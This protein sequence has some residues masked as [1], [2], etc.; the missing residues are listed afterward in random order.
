MCHPH[1]LS[2]E[3]FLLSLRRAPRLCTSCYFAYIWAGSFDWKALQR[4]SSPVR[5]D[6]VNIPSFGFWIHPFCCTFCC[7]L[8]AFYGAPLS[9]VLSFSLGPFLLIC[10]T[11][12]WILRRCVPDSS[13]SVNSRVFMPNVGNGDWFHVF[14]VKGLVLCRPALSLNFRFAH[15]SE[16]LHPPTCFCTLCWQRCCSSGGILQTKHLFCIL[17]KNN[18]KKFILQRFVFLW[19][20]L[21]CSL[22]SVPCVQLV[23]FCLYL[24]CLFICDMLLFFTF[25]VTSILFSLSVQGNDELFF[26]IKIT[27]VNRPL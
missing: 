23:S 2:P 5:L 25:W 19:T 18:V 21:R 27:W 22:I 1:G 14:V 20:L 15:G 10:W 17:P 8:N 16:T 6:A 24:S 13:H 7:Q 3:I 9:L 12:A 11:Q 4:A 26:S